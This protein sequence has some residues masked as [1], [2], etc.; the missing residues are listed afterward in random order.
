MYLVKNDLTIVSLRINLDVDA[1]C[2]LAVHCHNLNN[3]ASLLKLHRDTNGK[4]E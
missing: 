4:A 2:L 3:T 1:G